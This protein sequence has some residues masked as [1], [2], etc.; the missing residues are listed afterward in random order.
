M[1]NEWPQPAEPNA[2]HPPPTPDEPTWSERAFARMAEVTHH[3]SHDDDEHGDGGGSS[4]TQVPPA[5]PPQVVAPTPPPPSAPASWDTYVAPSPQAAY[6][7]LPT[8]PAAPPPAPASSAPPPPRPTETA[9]PAE[10][11]ED[12]PP[13][14]QFLSHPEEPPVADELAAAPPVPGPPPDAP[15]E[16]R[17]EEA[18]TV[19][20]E[21]PTDTGIVAPTPAPPR[22][23]PAPQTEPAE[24]AAPPASPAQ[25][26]LFG[27]SPLPPA[28]DG[29]RTITGA[30]AATLPIPEVPPAPRQW[31]SPP[32]MA[33]A[34][35]PRSGWNWAA[36]TVIGLGVFAL[37]IALPQFA[38]AVKFDR[39]G[40]ARTEDWLLW[41]AGALGAVCLVS[42]LTRLRPIVSALSGACAVIGVAAV[43]VGN[44]VWKVDAP[45][46]W[47]AVGLLAVYAV[48]GACAA[49]ALRRD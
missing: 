4:A 39:F 31:G 42:L 43:I 3:G 36:G 26:N 38:T 37:A 33:V 27:S 18:P 20:L 48:L 16:A 2:S 25:R 15:R 21:R 24:P 46:T 30:P 32:P 13:P 23:G 6:D 9:W 45:A 17:V 47:S 40:D 34:G 19:R 22:P 29:P 14:P 5:P 35:P 8:A 10:T 7:P 49:I 1:S 44:D 11:L 41:A 12:A 28:F